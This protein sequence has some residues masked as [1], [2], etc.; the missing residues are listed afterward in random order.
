M[1]RPKT[2]E[3]SIVEFASRS[4]FFSRLSG[5]STMTVM[6]SPGARDIL[7]EGESS[8]RED[9]ARPD[10]T[11][12][13]STNRAR[14][15]MRERFSPA[16]QRIIESAFVHE[17]ADPANPERFAP[18]SGA[19]AE[20]C[21]LLLALVEEQEGRATQLLE[22]HGLPRAV[23]LEQV[24]R[25]IDFRPLSL[26]EL[27]AGARALSRERDVEGTLTSEFF[28]LAFLRL[29]EGTR[30]VLVE[31]GLRFPALEREVLGEQPAPLPLDEALL[32]VDEPDR[33]AAA[34][35]LDA[36]ANRAREALRV[37][38]DYC[39]FV[40][41]DALLTGEIKGLRHELAGLLDS[42]PHSLLAVARETAR[43]VGTSLEAAAEMQRESPAAVARINL[44]RLQESL[45][46]LEEFGKIV[47]PAFAEGVEQIRYR[48]YTLEKALC[49]GDDA[50]SKLSG[51]RLYVLLRGAQCTAALDWTIAE[52]AAG[53]AAIFQLREKELD[54]RRLLE[55]AKQVRQWVRRAG[56]LFIMND[57]P[58]LARL[59]EADG[60]HLGQDDMPVYEAR[61]ILGP[62]A[63]I[64]VSTHNLD[65]VRRAVDD[66]AS[67]IG[68]GPAFASS[69]KEFAE[70]AG[71]DF[72]KA[73][74]EATA[75][76]AFA[77]GGVNLQ[78]IDAI[79]AAGARRVA[80]SAALAQSDD[81]R[82]TAVLL[83]QALEPP[84]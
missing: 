6:P 35:V 49:L 76:P 68:V 64:G 21:A 18:P 79:A 5:A 30:A 43:D 27:L 66:G 54:D 44:K 8:G 48:A 82:R 69:T 57:R 84:V 41:D 9:L 19:W 65:Q 36:N 59:A 22:T 67:Y 13:E 56:G 40:R 3:R 61:R 33:L 31:R 45:R 53:G 83:L 51:A 47:S 24:D 37:L 12:R 29:D 2:P 70:L 63:L 1:H 52:A 39:R 46:S 71:V 81:P 75:L 50:C 78:T 72:V 26:D 11:T 32:P 55:R 25:L 15:N 77:I 4:D 14:P 7:L 34:R 23:V 58:D 28:L 16:V 62:E 38:D 17:G 80:V 10:E 74:V 42:L 20:A 73:A 60:V